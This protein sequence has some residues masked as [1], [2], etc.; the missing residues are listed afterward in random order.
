MK[1]V[2]LAST[3]LALSAGS[4]SAAE[5]NWS[6]SAGAGV[7]QT[8]NTE[9]EVWSGIDINVSA[10]TTTDSGITLSVSEDW[11]G[12]ELAD[13]DDDYAIEAQTSDLDTPTLTIGVGGTTITLENQA[14]DDL[15]DDSQ[16]GDIGIAST[17]GS[18]GIS[19]VMDTDAAAG[20]ASLS[21]S[22]SGSMGAIGLSLVGTD[23][24]D[25]GNEATKIAASYGAGDLTYGASID[26]NGAA[27]DV[28]EVTV[29]YKTGDLSVSFAADDADDW[30]MSVGYNVSGI[31]IN[32]A[33]DKAEEWEANASYDL[34]GGATFKAAVNHAEYLAAGMQFSF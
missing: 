25:N 10:S 34:G 21:Y 5:M 6:G 22:L 15:Y 12:G 23:A 3:A 29:A 30:S 19:V 2:L 24:N 8:A 18:L 9:L 1:K 32:Y 26:D 28:T 11:G 7:G 31:S 17:V 16:N 4:L 33:T 27:D 13:Y 20:E 14:I